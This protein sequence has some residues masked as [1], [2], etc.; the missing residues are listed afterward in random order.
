MV[1]HK[2]PSLV[3]GAGN[4]ETV[5]SSWVIYRLR[6]HHERSDPNYTL[7]KGKECVD[8]RYIAGRKR[9]PE[10]TK[11]LNANRKWRWQKSTLTT[12]RHRRTNCRKPFAGE[13]SAMVQLVSNIKIA[14]VTFGQ[15]CN[16]LKKQI[17]QEMMEH[18]QQRFIRASATFADYE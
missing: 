17:F 3:L 18:S 14:V 9:S 1:S 10:Y 4:I 13:I 11:I 6:A 8:H 16:G 12:A 5:G 7:C 2:L 15:K